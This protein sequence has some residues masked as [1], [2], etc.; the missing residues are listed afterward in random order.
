MARS[1]AKPAVA[2]ILFHPLAVLITLVAAE[3]AGML[4]VSLLFS[5]DKGYLVLAGLGV[6]PLWG[7]LLALVYTADRR[8]RALLILSLAAAV[9]TAIL[10]L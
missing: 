2:G 1:Q 9:A 6:L 5:R 10:F 8:W 4:L 3:A 7:T